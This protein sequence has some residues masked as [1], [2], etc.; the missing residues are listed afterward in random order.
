MADQKTPEQIEQEERI[1]RGDELS[2]AQ[3]AAPNEDDGAQGAQGAQDD[4]DGMIPRTVFNARLGEERTKAQQER[5]ERIRLETE[6]RLLRESQKKPEEPKVDIRALRKASKDALSEGDVDKSIEIDEQIEAELD[7]RRRA[8]LTQEITAKVTADVTTSYENRALAKAAAQ[9]VK[10]Y[11]FLDNRS[12]EADQEE[13]EHV[14]I[15]RRGYEQD[16]LPPAEALEKAVRVV[17]KGHAKAAAGGDDDLAR[18]RQALATSRGAATAR[19]QPAVANA[20]KGA[21]ATGD[22]V[23][24]DVSK[25]TDEE[26]KALPKSEIARLRGDVIE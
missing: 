9:V 6:N 15:L 17:V 16:G 25:L 5:D 19:M 3:K 13:I 14:L 20:G 18:R 23:V 12:P 21:R 2:E 7:R 8:E 4:D 22:V 11:P 24:T 26:L 10:D 1:A